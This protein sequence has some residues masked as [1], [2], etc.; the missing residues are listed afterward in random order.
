VRP[1]ELGGVTG[2]GPPSPF[3]DPPDRRGSPSIKWRRYG[4]GVIPAWVADMDFAVDDAVIAA[5]RARLDHPVLGYDGVTP[6][7]EAAVLAYLEDF[8]SW[9]VDAADL[10]WL[11]GVVPALNACA[12]MGDGDAVVV[13]A[14]V[15]PPFLRAP[16]DQGRR[17][18]RVG[19][20]R[21]DDRWRLDLEELERVAAAAGAAVLLLCHPHNPLGLVFDEEELRRIA[22]IC[23]RH[24]LILCS[25]EIHC[26]LV[27]DEGIAFRSPGELVPGIADRTVTLLAP[28]KTYNIA[29]CTTA[30]AVIR[31]REL[32]RAFLAAVR[33]MIGETHALGMV[34]CE[35]AYRHG[36]AWRRELLAYLRGNRDRVADAVAAIDGVATTRVDATHLAWLDVRALGLD[37]PA[38]HFVAHGLGMSDGRDFG[39]PGFLRLNFGCSR[40]LLDE[41]CARLARGTEAA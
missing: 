35:A 24:D 23:E 31:D 12:A 28:S 14:P 8:H 15:Y 1:G 2:N 34:A 3:D 21:D 10:L 27:L 4:E 29:G 20:F 11:P 26:Q 16:R 19:F 13:P 30:F 7:L 32:R 41:I 36:G 25:D 6:G 40:A 17:L 18:L 38:R 9:K 37:D 33:G 5:L 39:E 22:A